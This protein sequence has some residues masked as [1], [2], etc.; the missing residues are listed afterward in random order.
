MSFLDQILDEWR[1]SSDS[2]FSRD[3]FDDVRNQ[4]RA[5]KEELQRDKDDIINESRNFVNEQRES[6]LAAGWEPLVVTPVHHPH[7][8]QN[9]HP[10]DKERVNWK[11]EGF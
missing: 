10:K 9:L 8:T 6:L 5:M 3:L 7:P 2:L 1:D 4:F 11:E